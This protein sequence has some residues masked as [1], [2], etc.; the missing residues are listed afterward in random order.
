MLDLF[1]LNAVYRVMIFATVGIIPEDGQCPKAWIKLT[2]KYTIH[3]ILSLLAIALTLTSIQH[4]GKHGKQRYGWEGHTL[5]SGCSG[6]SMGRPTY[7]WNELGECRRACLA[8]LNEY[9]K[10]EMIRS[11][12]SN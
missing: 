11:G 7:R 4:H 2:N 10:T 6:G 8:V 12:E 5:E 9:R 1:E 3:S